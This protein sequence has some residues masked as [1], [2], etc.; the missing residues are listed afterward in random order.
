MSGLFLQCSD[1]WPRWFLRW[2]FHSVLRFLKTTGSCG[3]SSIQIERSPH[4][5]FAGL[6]YRLTRS[7]SFSVHRVGQSRQQA[8]AAASATASI[9]LRYVS[10]LVISFHAMRAILL[11]RATA[12]GFGFFLLRR[13]R[14]HGVARRLC[15]FC[16]TCRS[17]VVAPTTSVLLRRL[18]PALVIPPCLTL[19][20][21]E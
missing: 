5:L 3:V 7:R 16:L 8:A 6:R 1:C 11:A 9:G 15:P 12:A 2:K 10:P 19:P 4:L 20:P 14:S 17:T 21:E 18:S 13:L